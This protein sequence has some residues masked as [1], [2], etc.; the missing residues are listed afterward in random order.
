[1]RGTYKTNKVA[2]EKPVQLVKL[3]W[4]FPIVDVFADRSDIN[5]LMVRSLPDR[6]NMVIYMEINFYQRG[7]SQT[8][9]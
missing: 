7:R 1:L 2:V 9:E 5:L 6:E 3:D 4:F 8:Q